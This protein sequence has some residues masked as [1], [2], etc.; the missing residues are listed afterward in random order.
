MDINY[1]G[2]LYT[3]RLATE[4]LISNKKKG[5]LVFFSSATAVCG[6]IGYSQYTPS[7]YALRGLTDCLR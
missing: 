3:S 4:S 1:F 2:C 7:K 5:K 6:M